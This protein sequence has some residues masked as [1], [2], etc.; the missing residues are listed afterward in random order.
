MPVRH[1]SPSSS[2]FTVTLVDRALTTTIA[3]SLHPDRHRHTLASYPPSF[4]PRSFN[5]FVP[6]V[7]APVIPST[8]THRHEA[9]VFA[10]SIGRRGLTFDATSPPFT[11]LDSIWLRLRPS[12]LHLLALCTLRAPFS[13]HPFPSPY[14]LP[15]SID[16]F[17]APRSPGRLIGLHVVSMLSFAPFVVY[18]YLACI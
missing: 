5:L 1:V 4:P 13:F 10:P 18:R 16:I 12:C 8:P 2:P 7:T 9:L 11:A 17:C 14:A 3:C 15:S 6:L